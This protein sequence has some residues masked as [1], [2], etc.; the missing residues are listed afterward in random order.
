MPAGYA[1][2]D[3]GNE[4]LKELPTAIQ[5]RIKEHIEFYHIGV[6]GPDILFYHQALKK[7]KISSLGFEMHTMNAYQFFYDAKKIIQSSS[8]QE[9]SLAYILGFITHFVLDSECHG[10]IG[11]MEKELDMTHSE[12]ESELDRQ[13]LLDNGLNPLTTSLTSHIHPSHEKSIVIAPFFK[14][15][16]KDIDRSLKDLLFFLNILLA[17]GKIKRFFILLAMKIAGIY[18]NY[19]KLMIN[20]QKNPKSEHA[21]I[22]LIKEKE[23]AINIAKNLILNYIDFLNDEKL[24]ERYMRTYE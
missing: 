13:L 17:P 7:N 23:N 19:S 5:K 20:Y 12:L 8:H 18:D 4:V 6:H 10:Y 14:L 22:E 9:E 15:D 3:F 11:Q 2:F 1:H 21:I 16:E 24:S